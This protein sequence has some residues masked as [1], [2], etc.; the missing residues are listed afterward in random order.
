MS[1]ISCIEYGLPYTFT[2]NE[3]DEIQE[4]VKLICTQETLETREIYF[5]KILLTMRILNM[6]I[7][8]QS[9]KIC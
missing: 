4:F 5:E 9:C 7:L 2:L 3:C 6:R 8:N 1:S